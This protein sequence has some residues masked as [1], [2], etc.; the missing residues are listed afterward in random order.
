MELVA[1]AKRGAELSRRATGNAASASVASMSA[2]VK[3][4]EVSCISTRIAR[5][6]LPSVSPAP[7][8]DVEQ[9]NAR[10]TWGGLALRP[11][12][13]A[14]PAPERFSSTTS[15]R[16]RR[17]TGTRETG[18]PAG[19]GP[20]SAALDGRARRRPAP[21][22]VEVR[23]RGAGA[24]RPASRRRR[25]RST[26]RGRAA[27]MQRRM[28]DRARSTSRRGATSASRSPLTSKKSTSRAGSP[29]CSG[30]GAAVRE[31]AQRA[32]AARSRP[33]RG[34]TCG[35]ARRS[36]RATS[37]RLTLVLQRLDEAGQQRRAHDVEL[38]GDRVQHADRLRGGIERRFDRRGS[39]KLN[40]TIS[41][42]SRS[43]S[44][45]LSALR[46]TPRLRDP[47]AC[48][49]RARAGAAGMRVVAVHA[50]DFLDEVLLDGEVEAERRRRHDE[51]GA[52]AREGEAEAREHVGDR[53]GGQRD[54]EEARR[55]ARCARAPGSRRGRS[56][57]RDRVG[58]RARAAAA[59][60]EDQL[61]RALDRAR[62]AAEV[63]AALE[64]VARVAGEAQAPHLALDHRGIPE[65]AFE[66][67]ARRVVGDAGVLA[68]HDAG[69][70]QRL[71]LVGD[72]QQVRARGRAPGRSAA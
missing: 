10:S 69:Q 25:R 47:A 44:A 70:A 22:Q 9:S 35:R 66:V 64:A 46:R 63:D 24:A 65:R 20:P 62:A 40:V 2:S 49:G 42:Q 36:G 21:G 38:R 23:G 59:D 45:R 71:L 3:V 48:A 14:A 15:A 4:R 43:T 5:L 34:G 72:E 29:H 26:T 56:S 27:R 12:R 1:L 28:R 57:R 32:A 11:A 6:F 60:F 51:V 17:T 67:D 13:R 30:S 52:F 39:T 58:E 37:L 55:R 31:A 8:V 54:A 53:V 16:S 19:T 18:L 7:A 33:P 61:R 41:C 68:A 50:R